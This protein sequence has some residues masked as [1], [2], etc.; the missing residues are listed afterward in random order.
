METGFRVGSNVA[1]SP[2]PMQVS[3][4]MV[5]FWVPELGTD[6]LGIWGLH[7]LDGGG[8]ERRRFDGVLQIKRIMNKRTETTEKLATAA[9][10]AWRDEF[11]SRKG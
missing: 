11:I 7:R 6:P 1:L 8:R 4:E 2:I 9:K 5:L 3:S 10:M